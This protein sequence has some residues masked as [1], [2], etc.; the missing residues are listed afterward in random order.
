MQKGL[1]I[2]SAVIFALIL[3]VGVLFYASP[4]SG[5]MVNV[6]LYFAYILLGIATLL[7]IVLPLPL[8]MQYPKKIKR[9]GG[10]ILLVAILFGI[11]YMLSSGEPININIEN[12]PSEQVLKFTDTALIITYIMIAL[13]ILAILGGGLKSI[14]DKKQ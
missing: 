4:E 8:L 9:V 6:V 10:A 11:G 5:N 2:F 1:K 7:A 13:S 12:Q 14:L 3:I